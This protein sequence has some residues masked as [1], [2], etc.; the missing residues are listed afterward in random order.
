MGLSEGAGNF[1]LGRILRYLGFQPRLPSGPGEGTLRLKSRDQGASMVKST[2]ERLPNR[3]ANGRS[4]MGDE[5]LGRNSRLH[6]MQSPMRLIRTV[7]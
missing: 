4:G 7:L 3:Q 6:R 1:S 2:T 5:V